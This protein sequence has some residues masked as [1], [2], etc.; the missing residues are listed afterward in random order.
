MPTVPYASSPTVRPRLWSRS[1]C[2][3][4]AAWTCATSAPCATPCSTRRSM[5]LRTPRSPA[6]VGVH[7][8][9]NGDGVERYSASL[10]TEAFH[11]R[12]DLDGDGVV[13]RGDLAVIEAHFGDCWGVGPAITEGWDGDDLEGLLSTVDVWMEL[14]GT[15]GDASVV[16]PGR[17]AYTISEDELAAR[18]ENGHVLISLPTSACDGGLNLRVTRDGVSRAFLTPD[19]AAIEAGTDFVLDGSVPGGSQRGRAPGAHAHRPQLRRGRGLRARR[20][21]HGGARRRQPPVH[22]AGAR[23]RG[24]ALCV[25]DLQQPQGGG[26][27]QRNHGHPHHRQRVRRSERHRLV[28][29]RQRPAAEQ[30]HRQ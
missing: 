30:L 14:P 28:G 2:A 25:R 11:S 3:A 1:P 23:G 15:E 19:G 7:R 24:L 27:H 17:A 4:M 8:D 12:F 20:R 21:P 10:L 9:Q 29:G 13:G 26:D 22:G 5:A 18:E 16:Q 6:T